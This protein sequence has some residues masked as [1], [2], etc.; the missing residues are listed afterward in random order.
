MGIRNCPTKWRMGKSGSLCICRCL[1]KT[2]ALINI[3]WG[4]PSPALQL[5]QTAKQKPTARWPPSTTNGPKWT[6]WDPRAELFLL[7]QRRAEIIATVFRASWICRDISCRMGT[8]FLSVSNGYWFYFQ[9][10]PTNQPKRNPPLILT[11]LVSHSRALEFQLTCC[12]IQEAAY[13]VKWFITPG[14]WQQ[15]GREGEQSSAGFITQKIRPWEIGGT[16][17]VCSDLVQAAPLWALTVPLCAVLF[18]AAALAVLGVLP[19]FAVPGGAGG[20]G[21]SAGS[22]LSILPSPTGIQ[23][24]QP[25]HLRSETMQLLQFNCVYL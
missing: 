6:Q 1:S 5:E 9:K 17:A 4:G 7:V 20:L 19:V 15:E 11:F 2:N 25:G 12:H 16:N 24:Q 18:A 22:V 14:W 3:C 23:Q 13:W 21:G 8:E 10:K